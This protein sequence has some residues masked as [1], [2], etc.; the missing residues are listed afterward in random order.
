MGAALRG[1]LARLAVEPTLLSEF[2]KR[3]TE[4]MAEAGLTDEER[5]AMM[6]HDQSRIQAAIV[7]E[8]SGP[9]AAPPPTGRPQGGRSR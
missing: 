5:L 7:G 9:P 2:I 1:F 6:S 4:I 3:P 8:M